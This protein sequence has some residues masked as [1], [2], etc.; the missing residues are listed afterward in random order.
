MSRPY[1]LAEHLHPTNWTA[2]QAV[3]FL[4]RR[5]PTTPFFLMVSF[6]QPHSPYVPPPWY[7]D[8][9]AERSLPEPVVGDWAG[10]HEFAEDAADP[11]AW[12]GRRSVVETQRARA[13]YY[14]SI[15]HI[16]H[17]IGRIT[18]ELRR[19]R[20]DDN[21]LVIFTS[22]HGDMLGDHHL[23]RKNHGYEGS[24]HI[25]LVVRLPR[26][27]GSPR[28]AHDD[29]PVC[30]QDVA[31]T[32]LDVAGVPIPDSVDGRSL[33]PLATGEG[34]DWRPYVHGEYGLG[35]SPEQ[36]MQYL[37][38]GDWKYIWFPRTGAEQLF[39]LAED[40]GETRDLAGDRGHAEVLGQWRAALVRTLEP[41]RAGL[42]DGAELVVQTGPPLVSPYAM[43]R[44][45]D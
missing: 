18:A 9:Y 45:L 15:H 26:S 24:V 35:R 25:P 31:P 1:P 16:D 37:S 36:E 40:P 2:G 19:Q 29:S 23:W 12:R 7:F 14:G 3:Q 20:L 4:Q 21:T 8:L 42:T 34:A 41:R 43:D 33:R 30:L 10:V 5:D 11:N 39:H 22:D 44:R 28:V 13:G 17:Q 6:T 32:I 38:D 27:L